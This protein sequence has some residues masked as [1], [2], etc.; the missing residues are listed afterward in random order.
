MSSVKVE[1]NHLIKELTVDSTVHDINTQV[2]NA[3]QMAIDQ[4]L[5][6][7]HADLNKI[8]ICKIN[9]SVDKD[10]LL[11]KLMNSSRIKK[12]NIKIWIYQNSNFYIQ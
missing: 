6:S 12:F 4:L 5:K 7:R 11:G 9:D 10:R 8:I 2:F 1:I 3:L